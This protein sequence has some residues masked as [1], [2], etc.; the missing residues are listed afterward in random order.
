MI[1]MLYV[2]VSDVLFVTVMTP[3][4][5]AGVTDRSTLAARLALRSLTMLAP[6]RS[7][8]SI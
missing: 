1:L 2:T 3:G 8:S 6:S 4:I 7:R 5:V